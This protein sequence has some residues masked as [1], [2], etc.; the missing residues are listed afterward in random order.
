MSSVLTLFI[1]YRIMFMEVIFLIT[2]VPKLM[3]I[4][5]ERNLTQMN[6]SAMSGVPQGTISRFDK[7]TR[8]DASHLFA[9]ARALDLNVED[10]FEVNEDGAEG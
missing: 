5:E 6:L 8:H 3:K 7:N 1:A 4:L 2:V 9:I 10:L